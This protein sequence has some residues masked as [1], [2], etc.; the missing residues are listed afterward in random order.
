MQLDDLALVSH[1][2]QQMQGEATSLTAAS[3]GVGLNIHKGESKIL[4]HDTACNN[5]ITL[6]GEELEDVN[7]FTYLSSIIHE[8][9]GS[10]ADVKARIGQAN[11]HIYNCRTSGTQS[12]CQPTRRSGFSIQISR[13]LYC[14]LGRKLGELVKPSSR[15]YRCLLTVV[16][17]KYFGSVGQ[18]LSATI[19][20]GREQTRFQQGNESGRSARSG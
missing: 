2:Q 13:Q 8:H 17:E 12:N 15:R 19:Y 4:L 5:R 10:D 7:T 14:L 20:C 6:D 1:T 18:T 3:A 16:Y 11:Q 9:G